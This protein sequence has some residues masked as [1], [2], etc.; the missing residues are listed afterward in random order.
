[1]SEL[2]WEHLTTIEG[3]L[4][5]DSLSACLQAREIETKLFQEG[6]GSL[7]P[8]SFGP[9]SEVQIFVPKEKY[10]E[11]VML[12]NDFQEGIDDRSSENEGEGDRA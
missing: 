4:N 1:M 10:A 12:L 7:V 2:N 9:L 3:R 8:L 5:A 6:Y 11:A